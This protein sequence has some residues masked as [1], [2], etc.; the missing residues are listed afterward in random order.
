MEAP[1]ATA[2]LGAASF[3][4]GDQG[5]SFPNPIAPHEREADIPGGSLAIAH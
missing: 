3:G 5:A 1:R 4:V 2:A